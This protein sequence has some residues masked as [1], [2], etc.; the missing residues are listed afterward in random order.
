MAQAEVIQRIRPPQ[1]IEGTPDEI[2]ERLKTL[3]G[4]KRLTLIIPGEEIETTEK[5]EEVQGQ[6]PH[7][8]MTFREIFSPSQAGFDKIGMTDDELSDFLEAEV[9]AYRAERR[10]RE[11]EG[12]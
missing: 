1:V 6:L 5:P 8:G 7:A 3:E 9:K 2:A 11:Q 4:D 10:D 12:E